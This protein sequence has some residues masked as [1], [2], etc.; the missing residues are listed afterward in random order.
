MFCTDCGTPRE[1]Q[2]AF[3]VRCGAPLA[4]GHVPAA[5]ATAPVAPLAA[6]AAEPTAAWSGPA[7]AGWMGTAPPPAR[8]R[9]A[10]ALTAT[11]VV[12][13]AA[14]GAGAYL[15]TRP[16]PTATAA[17]ELGGLVPGTLASGPGPS[18]SA[19]APDPSSGPAPSPSGPTASR[20]PVPATT[21]LALAYDRRSNARFG[22]AS[23]VPRDYLADPAPENGD[24]FH[25]G[26]K[27]SA[28]Q[29]A[30]LG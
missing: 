8:R 4:A 2:N 30:E 23:D 10:A 29:L 3:C 14:S 27:G 11:A 9:R 19:V 18:T 25:G 1:G 24:G 20:P 22:F 12:L 21:A 16:H 28:Q 5:P 26:F 6:V 13:L 17:T 15:L 7:D